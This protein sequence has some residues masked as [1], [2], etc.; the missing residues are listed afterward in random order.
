MVIINQLA[1][2]S[3]EE[4]N[5]RGDSIFATFLLSQERKN[6]FDHP[7]TS[8]GEAP[9]IAVP[10]PL[11]GCSHPFLSDSRRQA[12]M[13]DTQFLIFDAQYF[14]MAAYEVKREHR[15]CVFGIW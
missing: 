6:P 7:Y 2:M 9:T 13:L 5:L 12:Q 3:S 10:H 11:A 8:K 1:E 14:D 15:I 4:R